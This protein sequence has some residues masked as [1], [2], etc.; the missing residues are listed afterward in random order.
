MKKTITTLLTLT[1]AASLA[2][3]G[4]KPADEPT[5]SQ[6]TVIESAVDFYT[7][8]WDAFGEDKQFAAVGGDAANEA[9]APAK[10]A[11]TDENKETFEYLLHVSDELYDMLDDDTATLQHMMNTNTF[12]SAFAKL[13][14]SSKAEAFAEDYK[15]EIQGQHWMCGFPD[16]VV[17]ISVADYVMMVYGD[18]E[19]IGNL[20][21]ACL[22]VAP[23]SRSG[24][25]TCCTGLGG[26]HAFFQHTIFILVSALCPNSLYNDTGNIKKYGSPVFKPDF[27][28]LGRTEV[29]DLD[30][31]CYPDGIYIRID[32]RAL[33]ECS[34]ACKAFS[35]A[36]GFIQ[37]YD[38]WL[39]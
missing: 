10:F 17:V 11:M 22:K 13:K 25:C 6:D 21:E 31:A 36:F 9:E 15:A 23:D 38:A 30:G 14:D 2:G 7:E 34:E 16:K 24:G 28:W 8:V 33:S 20:V 5:K 27:L 32:D 3:C 37:P 18:E 12:S 26:I 29:C 19:C 1:M 39:F 4:S 35:P